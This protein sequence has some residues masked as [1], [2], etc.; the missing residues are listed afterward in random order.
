MK[1]FCKYC[2]SHKC[3]RTCAPSL[4]VRNLSSVISGVDKKVGE[5]TRAFTH[6]D[7]ENK[8]VKDK[9]ESLDTRLTSL[10]SNNDKIK[11]LQDA[12]SELQK[13]V[14]SSSVIG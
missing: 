6:L 4:I 2:R 1:N 11:S 10:E 13:K 8:V 3:N 7:A 12:V 5:V 9:V 14:D